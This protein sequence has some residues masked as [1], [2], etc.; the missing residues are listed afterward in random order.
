LEIAYRHSFYQDYETNIS[1]FGSIRS[2][3]P[4]SYT[5]SDPA[6]GRGNVFG[7]TSGGRYQVYVPSVANLVV[8]T[9]TVSAITQIDPIVQFSGT[10]AQLQAFKDF[11]LSS[12]LA[13]E[14]GK[15]ATR[16]T[17][18]NPDFAQVDLHFS[19]QI[20]TFVGKSR[21]TVF[22]DMENFLNLISDKFAFRQFG[23]AVSVVQVQCLDAGGALVAS[24]ATKCAS[25]RYSNFTAP[26]TAVQTRQSLWTLRLGV[27]FD[28]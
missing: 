15:I 8:P 26:N 5:F 4:F 13:G 10:S 11:I 19:Q 3:R 12:P 16:G 18:R 24:L 23:D 2:G 1:L 17:G 28:F 9:S 6:A 14:Q 27:R 25:Y 7:T 22:A 20:P 21:V